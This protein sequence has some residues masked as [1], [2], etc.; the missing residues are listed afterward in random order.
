MDTRYQILFRRSSTWIP[1]TRFYSGG[2]LLD[3]RYQI[4]LRR[5]STWIPDTRF[6]LGGAVHGYKIPGFIQKEQYMDTRYQI[7]FRRSITGYQISDF[8]KEE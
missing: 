1:D 7:L 4:L 8:I 6:D 2:A 5:S 3:T